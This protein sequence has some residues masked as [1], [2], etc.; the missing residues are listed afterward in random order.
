MDTTYTSHTSRFYHRQHRCPDH[1]EATYWETESPHRKMGI[2]RVSPFVRCFSKVAL[3]S[4]AAASALLLL[5]GCAAGPGAPKSLP[6]PPSSASRS[7]PWGTTYAVYDP[8]LFGPEVPLAQLIKDYG[9]GLKNG[10]LKKAKILIIK[11]QRRLELWVG[12]KMVKAYRIQLGQNPVGPKMKQGDSRTP[13]G[14]YFICEH[15]PSTYHRGLLISYPN[16]QDARRGLEAGLISQKQFDEIKAAIKEGRCPPQNTKLGGL[17]LMHGQLPEYTA[18]FERK[19]KA[20]PGSL[21]PGLEAG[22]ANP[23]GIREFHDWTNGCIALFNPDIRELYEFVP[24]GTPVTIVANG[25]VTA[26]RK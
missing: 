3:W 5:A 14:E 25:P 2:S 15:R 19:Q 6:P 16:V 24:D 9:L 12:K 22:D 7:G 20:R 13:E 18:D 23:A 10:Q 1:K 4:V 26:P 21:R 11:S 17:I 8:A